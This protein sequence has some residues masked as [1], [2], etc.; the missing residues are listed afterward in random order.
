M[1]SGAIGILHPGEMGAAVAKLLAD[2]GREV[3]YASAC[4]SQA[5]TGRAKQAG[6]VDAGTVADVVARAD[7][8]LSIC[9]PHGAVDVA[10]EVAG[11]RGTY[12]DANAVSPTTVR[13]IAS[14]IEAGGGTFVD[15]GII[16]G[17]PRRAGTRLYLSGTAAER[18]AALFADTVLDART[19]SAEI[20]KA[21]ALKMAYA[22][23]SKGTS[24]MLLA[25]QALARAE[26]VEDALLAEWE[27]SQP[28]LAARR[29]GAATAAGHK[30][31]RWIAEMEE[32]AATFGAAG[33][34]A[35]FHQAAAEIFT[36][37]PRVA[38]T[39]PV[40][41]DEVVAALASRDRQDSSNTTGTA[42]G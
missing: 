27:L 22:G 28:Q 40:D 29:E 30:G 41:L 2:S 35:G 26:G 36:R 21:S 5:T 24:A 6:L 25:I 9:P 34:P 15:G 33:L 1:T 7:V 12:V 16:G 14:L 18:V 39:V 4:R 3:V 20:G 42:V 31:W 38:A 10:R 19:V 37:A 13:T 11:F 32:I 23:W 8:V 17:P